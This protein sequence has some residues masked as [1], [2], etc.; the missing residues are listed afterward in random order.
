MPFRELFQL[1]PCC[2]WLGSTLTQGKMSILKC[3]TSICHLQSLSTDI[4]R[5]SKRHHWLTKHKTKKNP[6]LKK[7]SNSQ[8]PYSVRVETSQNR[9]EMVLVI[10]MLGSTWREGGREGDGSEGRPYSITYNC[11]HIHWNANIWGQDSSPKS[12]ILRTGLLKPTL[13]FSKEFMGFVS[14]WSLLIAT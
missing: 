4:N 2:L 6:I 8:T 7:N 5:L 3:C 14:K 1:Q 9:E 10:F 11:I 12:R 13:L